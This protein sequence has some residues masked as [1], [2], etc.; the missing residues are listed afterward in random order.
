MKKI[1]SIDEVRIANQDVANAVLIR[2]TTKRGSVPGMPWFGSRL[3][4]ITTLGDCHTR[5]IEGFLL[6]AVADL[7]SENKIKDVSATAFIENYKFNWELSWVDCTD[8]QKHLL[9]SPE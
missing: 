2:I 5:V 6:E 9:V 4:T 3:H 8:G 7:V 1:T